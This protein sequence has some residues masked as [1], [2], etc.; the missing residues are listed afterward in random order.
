MQSS[1]LKTIGDRQGRENSDI[2]VMTINIFTKGHYN[3]VSNVKARK[4][5]INILHID[6]SIIY[7]TL[8]LV[9]HEKY[10]FYTIILVTHFTYI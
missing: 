6:A 1:L 7:L 10:C 5:H 3:K 8:K 9:N 4:N 2:S